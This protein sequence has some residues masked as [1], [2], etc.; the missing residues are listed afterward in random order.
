[1]PPGSTA[2]VEGVLARMMRGYSRSLAVVLR[3]R[4]LTLI[5]ARRHHRAD[6]RPL[7]QHAEGLFPAGRYRASSAAQ[8]SP[9]PTSRS[10]AMIELQQRATDIVLADPAVAGARLLGRRRVVERRGQRRPPVHLAQA[11]EPSATAFRTL[12]V[13]ERMRDKP[14]PHSRRARLHVAGAAIAQCRRPAEPFAIPVHADRC[15]RRGAGHLG[16]PGAGRASGAI[17]GIIDVTTDREQGGLQANVVIDRTAASRLGVQV[18]DIDN[19]LNN[20]FSQR[21]ISTIFTQRNQYRVIL[22]VDPHAPARSLRSRPRL[23]RRGRRDPGAALGGGAA[24]EIQHAA[25]P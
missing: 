1:M 23:R 4:V 14:R 9:R 2:L 19:A 3:H 5:V 13:V 17:P 6:G 21:Q 12:A 24:D 22:E 18:Q 15:R 8:R 10:S 16:A 7:H 25:C 20:S 11:A